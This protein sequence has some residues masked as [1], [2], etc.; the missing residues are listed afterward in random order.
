MSLLQFL[1]HKGGISPFDHQA[2]D[3]QSAIGS[4]NKFVPGFGNLLR[5][6][7]MSLD[8]A[9]EA[10]V[11]AGY[12]HD[13]A[14][15][16]G[17]VTESTVNHLLDAMDTELRGNKVYRRGYEPK[18]IEKEDYE[19]EPVPL[20]D[21]VEDTYRSPLMTEA[22]EREFS[23]FQGK[24]Q[25]DTPEFKK[26]FGGSKVV[27]RSGTPQVVYHGTNKN[28]NAFNLK[29]A[30]QGIIWFTSDK[31]AVEQGNVGAQGQ[32][33]ILDLYASIKNPAGWK[34]YDQKSIGELISEGYDGVILPEKNGEFTGI[35]FEPTQLKSASR[36]SGEFNPENKSFLKQ[37]A[38]GGI[39][40]NPQ[41]LKGR[42]WLGS[43]DV[44]PI[45]RIMRD[46]NASTFIHESGH[47][48]LADLLRDA[49][50]DA[51]PDQLKQDAAATLKWLGIDSPDTLK[52]ANHEKFAR[53]FEQYLREGVAPSKELASVFAR[54]RQWLT[55]IYQTLKGLGKP[56]NDDIRSVFDRLLAEN[57]ERTV[58][59]PER[60]S[61]PTLAD[62]HEVDANLTHPAD[63]DAAKARIDQELIRAY[64][65]IPP[66]V[67]NEFE[68]Q[69]AEKAAFEAEG[70]EPGSATEPAG[71][72]GSDRGAAGKLVVSGGQS[73]PVASGG[74]DGTQHAAVNTGVDETGRQGAGV[75]PAGRQSARSGA[76]G[77]ESNPL[78]ANP[79]HT[80][81]PA[82]SGAVDKA[83]NIRVENITSVEG[84]AQAIHD[85]ADRNDDFR[86]VRGQATMGQMIDLANELNLDPTTIDENKLASMF[87]GTNELAPK[88]WALRKLVRDSSQV[89]FDA[90]RKLNESGSD[91][92]AVALGVATSRHDMIQGVLS[93]TTAE[94][95]RALGMGFRN[96]EGWEQAQNLSE[97]V[98]QSTGK[99]LYQ[100]KT[101]A[102]LGAQLDS[103]GKVS[104]F[105][106]DAQKRSFPGMVLEYWINGLISGV[107]THTTYTAGN[108]ALAA[109][110]VLLETPAA[111]MIGKLRERFGEE[112]QHVQL[113][114]A[115]ARAR[116]FI[117]GLPSALQASIE[118]MRSG[119]TTLLPGEEGR[120]LMPFS[121][122]SNLVV[123]KSATNEPVTWG[124]VR[125]D[126]AGMMRG[127]RD[128]VMATAR[129]VSAGGETGAPI[130][131]FNY[132]PLGQIPDIA[133]RG[134]TVLPVG[135][136]IRL[137][138]RMIAAIHSFFRASN[139]S[140]EKAADAYRTASAEGLK[141]EAFDARA[142]EIWTNPDEAR[143]ASYRHESTELT[144]MGQGSAFTQALSKL[145]NTPIG[146][147]R[148]LKF[149]DPFVHI[150][151][152][153]IDQSII[154]R[155]PLGLLSPEL[156]AD[157]MGRKDPV[158]GKVDIAAR[159]M[160]QARMLVGTGLG[161][162]FAGLASQGVISGSGPKD[163]KESAMWRLAGNQAHS[164]RIGD[165]WYDVHRLGPLGMLL[166][167]SADMWDV[168]HTATHEDMVTAASHLQHAI[169]QNIL[170]E[171]FMRGPAS[172]IQ[173]IEDPGRYGQQYIDNMLASF[174]PFSVGMAQMARAADPYSRQART[175]MDSI[176]AKVPGLSETLYP[177]RDIWGEEMPNL[178]SLG[179]RALTA[180]YEQQVSNDPVNR[181]MINLGISPAQ[182]ER[183]IRN[184]D[185]SDSQYDDFTRISG[186]MTKMRLDA[187]VKS[188]DY[189]MW[190]NNIRS[191]VI[192][193]VIR[194]SRE[195]ARGV[196]MMKY[197]SIIADS[198]QA[199]K[200]KRMGT[201][202][203]S[204]TKRAEM[205]R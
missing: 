72:A 157:L 205:G 111:A 8:R 62:I 178:P 54:F 172:L 103:P 107:A 148:W 142:G 112:G 184:V 100:L 14:E 181:A 126:A 96:M 121:G 104:K 66:E 159:D 116:G 127:L 110:R 201:D 134:A 21:T 169:T 92:D 28:F 81:D 91:A 139:Y 101:M 89:V 15:Q 131:G 67:R 36:N 1:A 114:E 3:V 156:R 22:D 185:L 108:I 137:P 5:A 199:Q 166:G 56:I 11:E 200:D 174:V 13:T 24:E 204:A 12:L 61:R 37:G 133:F 60:E 122:D 65:D 76:E 17:G 82:E 9:R 38:Q 44:K 27:D 135:S 106:R 29:K 80:F 98:K 32:G 51:A 182:P 87:G 64:D 33:K 165:T 144:L 123:G 59:A 20:S 163:P 43:E 85:S 52:R 195:A 109:N 23:L 154:K 97:F 19:H 68:A 49:Q 79:A 99:T 39:V 176:K 41:G 203:K 57:P 151:S 84:L 197:P 164:V 152:N 167:I 75:S 18:A 73:E 117:Q 155:T 46:G 26:W 7:G 31:A 130:A 161:I 2:A 190:P 188:P 146:G 124:E 113:G 171:S 175:V 132:S 90:M 16:H 63:A 34:E 143:M 202:A 58:I 129:L 177:R 95:G 125:G 160:A 180:F 88:I 192:N 119:V 47:Q 183:K 25:T 120:P 42:D 193:E 147:V 194:Q 83:G 162:T 94:T 55:D 179:G 168:A 35:A 45:L 40:L 186:R 140:M 149:I 115:G 141:G 198:T 86:A 187:I 30:T 48:Y 150:A 105:L 158:T 153:V 145:T 6:G 173:A 196:I 128:G 70:R 71:P 10:A 93:K 138:G 78:A 69:L 4:D 118:A 170:D 189:Q 53:G 102:K 191:T 50:H 77:S 136:A 74:S